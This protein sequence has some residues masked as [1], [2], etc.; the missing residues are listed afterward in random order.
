M[1]SILHII[2][3][4]GNLVVR[5]IPCSCWI[6]ATI[7]HFSTCIEQS[8]QNVMEFVF[9]FFSAKLDTRECTSDVQGHVMSI[10]WM[11]MDYRTNMSYGFRHEFEESNFGDQYGKWI[12]TTH[13]SFRNFTRNTPV[14]SW[15]FF[16]KWEYSF[17][18][19]IGTLC[20]HIFSNI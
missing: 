17:L 15:N 7:E 5:K 19:D 9:F 14:T 1:L 13:S 4:L 10:V 8:S 6:L 12:M 2:L 3:P 16:G 18:K 20:F 11:H